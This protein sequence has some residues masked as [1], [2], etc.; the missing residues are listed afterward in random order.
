VAC[1]LIDTGIPLSVLPLGTANNLAHSL[2]FT[3]SAPEI[4]ARLQGGRKR[5]VDIAIFF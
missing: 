3:S 4:I 2:G 1:R 5:A